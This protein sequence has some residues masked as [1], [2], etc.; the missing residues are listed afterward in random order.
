MPAGTVVHCAAT[1]DNSKGNPSNPDPSRDVSWGR[2][3]T[4]EMMIGFVDYY[5]VD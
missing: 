1:Y 4:A 5:E 2:E 3:T